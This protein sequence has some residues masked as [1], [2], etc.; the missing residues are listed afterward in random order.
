M[1]LP[2]SIAKR[3]QEL[4]QG[5]I[6]ASS[7]AKHKLIEILV[8]EHIIERQG[9]IQKKLTLNNAEALRLYLQN[10]FGI[11]NLEDYIQTLEKEDIQRS[12]LV[13]ASSNSKTKAVRTFKGF[14]V[15]SFQPV[16]ADLNGK[17]IR[18]NF[19]EGVFQF[20][21]DFE[22][23]VPDPKI[24]IVGIE[25]PENFRQIQN[26]QQLF[27]HF[28]PLFVSR[29]P[30]HQSKDLV[31]WLKSI[32]NSY[33]H[34]GDF[35]LSGIGIYMNEY[36]THLSDKASFFVP[37]NIEELLKRYGNADL[38]NHQKVNFKKNQIQDQK[39]LNLIDLIHHYQKG[40]EQEVL[41]GGI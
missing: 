41:V 32:P 10:K 24:T 14:L 4:L 28:H 40:L 18:L 8:A 3:L 22:S 1:K 16:K 33:L 25:N 11:N 39:L 31:R 37:D 35:D 38:Y 36:K 17:S 23:F 19:E 12:E 7:K 27:S 13:T 21:Y 15:N 29:Y 20:I 9:R 5:Q 26:Q 34:F 30:Q 6:L 2:L